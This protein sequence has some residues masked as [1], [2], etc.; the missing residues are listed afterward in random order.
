MDTDQAEQ[1]N[2]AGGRSAPPYILWQAGGKTTSPA[3]RKKAGKTAKK[4]LA[5]A[6]P[7]CYYIKAV[8]LPG[9]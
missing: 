8:Y 1:K 6:R 4:L 2:K 5:F 3:M 9:R 7:L